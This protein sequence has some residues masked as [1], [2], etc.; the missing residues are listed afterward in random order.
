MSFLTSLIG[1]YL[2]V[3]VLFSCCHLIVIVL[4]IQITT[5]V[6]LLGYCLFFVFFRKRRSVY[7]FSQPIYCKWTLFYTFTRRLCNIWTELFAFS[8]FK[9]QNFSRKYSGR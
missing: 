2:H 3:I 1:P 4:F 7:L 6:G 9:I 5:S 8:P